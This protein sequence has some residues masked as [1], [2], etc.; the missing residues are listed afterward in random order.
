VRQEGVKRREITSKC[1]IL[2]EPP[3]LR[4]CIQLNLKRLFTVEGQGQGPSIL[5]VTSH[6]LYLQVSLLQLALYKHSGTS[7]AVWYFWKI[8]TTSQVD[9]VHKTHY[10]V[11]VHVIPMQ[12]PG[13]PSYP[14]LLKLRCA[15][16]LHIKLVLH[17][18]SQPWIPPHIRPSSSRQSESP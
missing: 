12:S 17:H 15:L 5:V 6:F 10:G 1:I 8:L 13:L 7:K 14:M 3:Q 2:N 4:T 9:T 18:D 16:H 11:R